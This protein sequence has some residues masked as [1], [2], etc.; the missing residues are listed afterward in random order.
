VL[1]S[2]SSRSFDPPLYWP[3]LTVDQA[4]VAWQ[5]LRDWVE[6]Y[7]ARFALDSRTLPV[8]W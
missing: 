1:V 7:A 5:E 8:C 3:A 2:R 4:P 6:Q